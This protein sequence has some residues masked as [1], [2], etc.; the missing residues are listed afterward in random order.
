MNKSTI[1]S[2]QIAPSAEP[3]S[4]SNKIPRPIIPTPNRRDRRTQFGIDCAELVHFTHW[5]R[6]ILYLFMRIGSLGVSMS[7]N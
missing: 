6:M 7:N 1:A 4:I 2:N 3:A 5:Y